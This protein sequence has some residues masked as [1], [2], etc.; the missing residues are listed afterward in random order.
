MASQ[1][2]LPDDAC[3]GFRR[4]S[5]RAARA[6]AS[7]SGS[8]PGEGHPESAQPIG[9]QFDLGLSHLFF[10]PH[11]SAVKAGGEA[12]KIQRSWAVKPG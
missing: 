3:S 1:S 6:L 5:R 10:P 12:G 11:K 7:S 8:E 9:G 4:D 2:K